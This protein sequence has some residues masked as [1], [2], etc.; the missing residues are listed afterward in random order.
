MGMRILVAPDS[1]KGTATAAE[2]AAAIALGV[3]RALAG[4]FP[5][6]TVTL[7]LIHI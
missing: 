5:D 3:R 1:F 6:A 7:S 4:S 2:A